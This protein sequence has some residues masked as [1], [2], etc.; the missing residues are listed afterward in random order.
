MTDVLL[1]DDGSIEHAK[2]DVGGWLGWGSHTVAVPFEEMRV[3]RGK[4]ADLRVYVDYTRDEIV[5]L[6]TQ[7]S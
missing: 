6:P 1:G 2:V 3:L 7:D 5:R 4:D